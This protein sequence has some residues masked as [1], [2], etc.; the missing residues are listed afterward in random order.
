MSLCLMSLN[1]GTYQQNPEENKQNII[2]LSSFLS[3]S[4]P[5]KVM[6]YALLNNSNFIRSIYICFVNSQYQQDT[7]M[8]IDKY[9][10]Q[11]MFYI[12]NK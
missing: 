1:F 2:N 11:R 9:P 3:A 8:C 5:E 4:K 7:A 10:R 12:N 6:T